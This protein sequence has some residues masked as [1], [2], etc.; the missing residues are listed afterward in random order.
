MSKLGWID[1]DGMPVNQT[2]AEDIKSLPL[3]VSAHLTEEAVGECA[4]E[5]IS[6]WAEYPKHAKCIDKYTEEDVE[7]LTEV[8]ANYKC[9]N[10][11]FS[12]SCKAMV[13]SQ[14][15][16]MYSSAMPTMTDEKEV[17]RT[18][19]RASC[20]PTCTAANFAST[21]TCTFGFYFK[22][23]RTCNQVFPV[24]LLAAEGKLST[25]TY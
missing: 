16:E 17:D 11:I 1:E 13:E 8:G 15:Y 19:Q 7:R 21:T 12:Q 9:F 10:Y 24:L 25:G 23:T 18:F 4:M 3:E 5:M 14:I 6:G 22:F 2:M 20:L